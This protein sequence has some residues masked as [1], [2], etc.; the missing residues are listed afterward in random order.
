VVTAVTPTDS[1]R[2][3]RRHVRHEAT[4][5]EILDAAWKIVR[6]EGLNGLSLRALA[7]A[8]SMEPQSLYTYFSSKHSVYD[9]LFADGNH[10]LLER[11]DGIKV[12]G[13]PNRV[14]RNI[15]LLF[16]TF[17]SEDLA[18]YELLFLRTIP[19]FEPSPESYAVAVEVFAKGRSLLQA[20]GLDNDNDFDLWTALVAGLVS[21][22]L[23]ND[24]G[25]KRYIRLID[26]AVA[27]FS[28][29]VF[30]ARAQKR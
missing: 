22:Q 18:R 7:R 20:V 4:K 10:Q 3:D 30:G 15:A 2:R 11:I 1:V 8:V 9:H 27:M 19:E 29:H 25:G 16:V 17:A 26:D 12:T 5:R 28:E 24:P 6:V 13:D 14:L 21:Q 23:A